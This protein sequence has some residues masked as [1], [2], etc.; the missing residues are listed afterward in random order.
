[1]IVF[2]RHGEAAAGWGDHPDPGLSDKGWTQAEKV[3]ETLEALNIQHVFSSPMQ[4]CQETA[5]AFAKRTGSSVR[6]E[7]NVSEIPTPPNTPDRVTWLRTLMSGDWDG[8]EDIVLDWRNNLLRCIEALPDHS[9]VFS[10]FVAINALVGHLEGTDA[11]MV[12][13]PDHCSTTILETSPTGLILQQRG[14]E[15]GTNVL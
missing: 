8:S 12:F 14:A 3:A 15:A 6:I 7:P 9:V 10:H 13:R 2:V 11:V 1:M 4:R 5:S